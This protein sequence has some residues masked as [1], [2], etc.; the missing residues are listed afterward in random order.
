MKWSQHKIEFSEVDHPK[1][2]TTPSRY[3]IMVEPTIRNIEV[4]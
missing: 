2:V 3:P 4:A 1:I